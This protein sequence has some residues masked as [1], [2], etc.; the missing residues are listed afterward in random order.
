MALFVKGQ[1]PHNKKWF[2]ECCVD[3]CRRTDMKAHGLC[4]KHYKMKQGREKNGIFNSD[5]S[6]RLPRTEEHKKNNVAY[7]KKDG[8]VSSLK[9]RTYEDIYG[10]R[11]Y[12]ILK[13]RRG[14]NSGTW[15]GGKSFEKYGQEFTF[16]LKELVRDRD[17]RKCSECGITEEEIQESLVVHHIDNNKKNNNVIN[18]ISV[19]RICHGNI[20]WSKN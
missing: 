11:C 6:K 17:E 16:D 20:H 13:K 12:E 7:M 10:N 8:W 3:G 19:C 2:G 15:K 1:V 14:E 5:L 9:G 18:L 4:N